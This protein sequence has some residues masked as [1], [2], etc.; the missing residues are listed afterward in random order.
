MAVLRAAALHVGLDA[1][2]ALQRSS[3]LQGTVQE[4]YEERHQRPPNKH[5][6]EK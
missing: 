5:T 6:E 3:E 1:E 4:R 2:R